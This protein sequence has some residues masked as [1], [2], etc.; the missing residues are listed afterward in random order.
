MVTALACSLAGQRHRVTIRPGTR[1][2][3]L[4]GVATADEDFYCSYGVNPEWVSR[5]QEGG[6]SVSGVGDAGEARIV[7]LPRHPFYV[8]T[9]FIPQARSTA[10]EP[11]PLLVGFAAAATGRRR[12]VRTRG[13]ASAP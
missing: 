12:S 11:H 7:E 2:G 9:L 8:V 13:P 10:A 4:Y 5:L 6:L 1:A 3:T